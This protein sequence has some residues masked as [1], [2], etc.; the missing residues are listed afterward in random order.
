MLTEALSKGRS[1]SP[2]VGSSSPEG[3]NSRKRNPK[4][5]DASE[6]DE[7]ADAKK[8]KCTAELVHEVSK[9]VAGQQQRERN[10]WT[11]TGSSNDHLR[12]TGDHGSRLHP[13]AKSEESKEDANNSNATK[14]E[15]EGEQRMLAY[16]DECNG[17]SCAR[18]LAQEHQVLAK[19]VFN[20]ASCARSPAQEREDQSNRLGC[21]SRDGGPCDEET[22]RPEASATLNL[23][24]NPSPHAHTTGQPSE[25]GGDMNT[26][27]EEGEEEVTQR[28]TMLSG[29]GDQPE[30]D[31]GE[32][33]AVE[34]INVTC[35]VGEGSK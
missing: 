17:A 2:K 33:M 31:E 27:I 28:A 20:E 9:E 21:R 3:I 22:G 24:E 16:A 25:H 8:A 11:G 30:D 5:Q 19:E 10:Y 7:A 4:E 6:D 14:R 29:N 26:G 1:K 34:T 15:A 23:D 12:S 13:K 18:S 32:I 35:Y